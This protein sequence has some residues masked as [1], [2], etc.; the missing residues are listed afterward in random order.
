MLVELINRVLEGFSDVWRAKTL[1]F[2]VLKHI[3]EALETLPKEYRNEL[4][5]TMLSIAAPMLVGN[6]GKGGVSQ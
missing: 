3:K 1:K 5:G 4:A 2:L 6:E